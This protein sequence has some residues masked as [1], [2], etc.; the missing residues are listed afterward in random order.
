MKL[1]CYALLP[2]R[3]TLACLPAT[4]HHNLPLVLWLI[5][6]SRPF[7]PDPAKVVLGLVPAS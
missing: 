2:L 5:H 3:L 1:C 4:Q 7:P 6:K